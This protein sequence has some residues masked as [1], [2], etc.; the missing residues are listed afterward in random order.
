MEVHQAEAFLAVAE[1]LHFGRAA[2][3][4]RI[5]QPPLSRAIKQL[6]RELGAQLFERTTRQVALTPAGQALVSPAGEILAAST[7]AERTV[8]DTLSGEV[9]HVRIG[10]AG[11]SINRQVGQLARHLRNSHPGLNL[12][13]NS[14]QFSHQALDGVLNR[15]F[16]VAIG[17]WDFIPAEIESHVM[18]L[19]EVILAL[20]DTHPLAGRDAIAMKELAQESWVSLPSGFGAALPNRFNALANHAGFI[21]RITQTAPDSWTL[22]V[23][24]A[25]GMGCAITLDSVADNVPNDNVSFARIQ[26]VRQTPLEVRLIWRREDSNPALKAVI[27]VAENIFPDPRKTT[28]EAPAQSI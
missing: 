8:K 25:V 2:E 4:L 16:D 5:A 1:E 13:Y 7:R 15:S 20:P 17:R 12:E 26:G 22:M 23:L 9:G 28:L 11:A 19:E 6:E 21:P 10:F 3:R 27:E 14:S 24:V 18:G